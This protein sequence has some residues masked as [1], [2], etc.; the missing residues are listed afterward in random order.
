MKMYIAVFE[1]E[2]PVTTLIHNAQD[3]VTNK[4]T[5]VKIGEMYKNYRKEYYPDEL[6]NYDIYEVVVKKTK[7]E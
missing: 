7:G 2:D 1:D 3:L 6:N 4:K 5:A